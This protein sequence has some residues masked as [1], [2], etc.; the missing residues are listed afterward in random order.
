MAR[1]IASALLVAVVLFGNLAFAARAVHI[2]DQ[3]CTLAD[4]NG[5]FVETPPGHGVITDSGNGNFLCRAD[6]E[7]S[8]NG[9]AVLYN[10]KNTGASCGTPDGDTKDWQET[11]SAGGQAVLTCHFHG[12]AKS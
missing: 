6:V 10:F 4:G 11:V 12:N 2:N 8:A 5:E 1:N 3:T 9:K 7:P